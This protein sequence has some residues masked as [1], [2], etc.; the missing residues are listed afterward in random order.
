VALLKQG[1]AAAAAAEFQ[2][3][4]RLEPTNTVARDYLRQTQGTR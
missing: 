3:A 1:Q 2:E 4:V